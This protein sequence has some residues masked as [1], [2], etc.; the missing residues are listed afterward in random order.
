MWARAGLVVAGLWV[1]M[2]VAHGLSGCPPPH[3]HRRH[4]LGRTA[5]PASP[6]SPAAQP[7]AHRCSQAPAHSYVPT[8]HTHAHLH[9]HAHARP[10]PRTRGPSPPRMRVPR[11]RWRRPG[12]AVAQPARPLSAGRLLACRG[13]AP[14]PSSAPSPLGLQT[15]PRHGARAARN[16]CCH[17][18]CA[19]KLAAGSSG[20][21]EPG[22]GARCPWE[23]DPNAPLPAAAIGAE[24]QD[25]PVSWIPSV[26]TSLGGPGLSRL[27]GCGRG[28]GQRVPRATR[29]HVV[30]THRRQ[31]RDGHG[32][33]TA[34]IW[35]Q[36]W[37]GLCP[38]A[39]KGL[40]VPGCR[41]VPAAAVAS[42]TPPV[43][44]PGLA[45]DKRGLQRRRASPPHAPAAEPSDCHSRLRPSRWHLGWSRPAGRQ[46][47]P[48][49]CQCRCRNRVGAPIPGQPLG[50][51]Q[52]FPA[53]WVTSLWC[54]HLRFAGGCWAGI[55]VPRQPTL[56]RCPRHT[57]A[58]HSCQLWV[59]P[60]SAA[61][62]SQARGPPA[63]GGWHPQRRGTNSHHRAQHLWGTCGDTGAA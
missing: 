3:R 42:P 25:I 30:A 16:R 15:C 45:R 63:P 56:A 13:P 38:H 17:F 4:P 8:K 18:P 43:Q 55:T 47:P 28:E 20:A 27:K 33:G 24:P 29:R 23:P 35:W 2:W 36:W 37:P 57:G 19:G 9:T 14:R 49:P 34:G 50:T 54:C 11:W 62:H 51:S 26:P 44:V 48:Q 53:A 61:P 41:S 59:S 5:T 39:D 12:H 52:P 10:P 58:A 7:G 32:V 1:P 21:G 22:T 40:A 6:C 46:G 31:E 60:C